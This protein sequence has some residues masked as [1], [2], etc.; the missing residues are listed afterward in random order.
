MKEES[1]FSVCA[2]T[3]LGKYPTR[4]INSL[5]LIGKQLDLWLNFRPS[6]KIEQKRYVN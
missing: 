1:I 4:D 3:L 5:K 2:E 6:S